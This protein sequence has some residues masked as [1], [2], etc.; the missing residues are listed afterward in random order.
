M[1]PVS[2]NLVSISALNMSNLSLGVNSQFLKVFAL[3]HMSDSR[4]KSPSPVRGDRPFVMGVY[5][6][7]EAMTAKKPTQ[8]SDVYSFGVVL[9]ELLT[10]RS[11]FQQLSAGEL[12]LVSWMRASL[13]EKKALTEIFDPCLL[14][15]NTQESKLIETLQVHR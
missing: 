6:A 12:D 13:Q 3:I 5:Q 7:P 10:G 4:W 1:I 11:P 14:K 9:L 8:K 15:G 2:V